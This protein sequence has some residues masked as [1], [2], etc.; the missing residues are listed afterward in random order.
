MLVDGRLCGRRSRVGVLV[1]NG[2]VRGRRCLGRVLGGLAVSVAVG[3]W[4][5]VLVDVAVSVIVGVGVDVLVLVW[6]GVGVG[7]GSHTPSDRPAVVLRNAYSRP[8]PSACLVG[9][10]SAPSM[11]TDSPLDVAM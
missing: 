7:R 1:D 3:L 8:R 6:V 9:E 4:V 5:G 10:G 11:D 2:R